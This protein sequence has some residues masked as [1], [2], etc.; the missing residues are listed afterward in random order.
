MMDRRRSFSLPNFSCSYKPPSE[1][2]SF[3][4]MQQRP[5][6]DESRY[7]EDE[8][9]LRLDSYLSEPEPRNDPQTQ[10]TRQ[11]FQ[12]PPTKTT[13]LPIP[14][15]RSKDEKEEQVEEYL[16]EMYNRSTWQMYW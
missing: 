5:S 2:F 3:G 1:D 6:D 10:V 16:V 4:Y 11:A 12:A 15:P 14:C 13:S 9:D 7:F 8:S